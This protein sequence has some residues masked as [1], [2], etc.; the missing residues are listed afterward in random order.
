M[1]KYAEVTQEEREEESRRQRNRN[2]NTVRIQVIDNGILI[3]EGDLNQSI[4]GFDNFDDAIPRLRQFIKRR[5]DAIATEYNDIADIERGN[6]SRR[7]RVAGR[8]SR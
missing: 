6:S 4:V 1:Q 5:N 2:Q 8:G 3:K 7:V